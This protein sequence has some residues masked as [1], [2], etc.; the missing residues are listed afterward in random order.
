MASR[1]EYVYGWL[2]QHG[3]THNAASGLV[4][5]LMA[6]SKL[7][8]GAVGDLGIKGGAAHGIAQW[9]GPRYQNLLNYAAATRGN[10]N[11]LNTQLGFLN[12]EL[13]T[14]YRSVYNQIQNAPTVQQATASVVLGYERPK[15]SE[16]G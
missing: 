2:R 4:G 12:H 11:D 13:Q 9:R 5:N 3:Y 7:N 1:A 14:S 16:T 15:G 6:E 10:P 8:T